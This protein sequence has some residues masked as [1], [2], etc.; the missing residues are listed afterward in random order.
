MELIYKIY[1]VW[2]YQNQ[3]DHDFIF[4]YNRKIS[5]SG[6]VEWNAP[7]FM[8]GNSYLSA[9]IK[10]SL[11]DKNDP[12]FIEKSINI[13]KSAAGKEC[14]KLINAKDIIS[15]IP[16]GE[17]KISYSGAQ[18]GDV[19]ETEGKYKGLKKNIYTPY[20]IMF[21]ETKSGFNPHEFDVMGVWNAGQ[22]QY[23]SYRIWETVDGRE[24]EIRDRKI[25]NLLN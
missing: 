22:S 5:F 23:S 6:R 17:S 16:C 3:L 8:F 2:L 24:R 7:F 21:N 15:L 11:M 14:I 4:L 9:N 13:M 12:D 1:S 10:I 20:D 18:P 25:E 19:V